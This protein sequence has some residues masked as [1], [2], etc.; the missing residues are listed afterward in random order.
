MTKLFLKV[1]KDLF[2]LDLNPTEILIISQIIEFQRNEKDCFM[3]DEAFSDNLGVSKSTI[4]REI[5]K[6]EE[7][8]IIIKSTKNTRSGRSRVMSINET[9]LNS[10]I[11]EAHKRDSEESAKVKLTIADSQ[12][13]DCA[14]V[15]LPI[16][17]KQI[18]FIKDNIKDNIKDKSKTVSPSKLVETGGA[19]SAQAQKP[20]QPKAEVI[21]GIEWVKMSKEEIL[22]MCGN[23]QTLISLASSTSGNPRYRYQDKF[24]EMI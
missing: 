11:A 1:D 23:P 4:S 12:I 10:L 8:K 21:E 2:L 7:Q 9:T 5:K 17:N 19:V 15:N 6:L 22:N 24:I 16:A 18:D 20:C 14:K 13:D 3:S